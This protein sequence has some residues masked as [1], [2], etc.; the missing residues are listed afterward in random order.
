MNATHYACRPRTASHQEVF[1]TRGELDVVKLKVADVENRATA[2]EGQAVMYY[3]EGVLS[4][5]ST[6]PFF[7]RLNSIRSSS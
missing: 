2:S 4:K 5:Q 6:T 1:L 3:N 7:L